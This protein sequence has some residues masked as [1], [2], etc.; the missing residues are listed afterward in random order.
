MG[1]SD[2][3]PIP[4]AICFARS[5]FERLTTEETLTEMNSVSVSCYHISQKGLLLISLSRSPSGSI[6]S[7]VLCSYRKIPHT[8]GKPLR[9]VRR[10]R[11]RAATDHFDP[12]ADGWH[13]H[14]SPQHSEDGRSLAGTQQLDLDTQLIVFAGEESSFH[15]GPGLVEE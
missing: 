2:F 7:Y 11:N 5:A 13:R 12:I 10:S 15:P 1:N 14:L 3:T 8:H 4:A 6:G 9:Q